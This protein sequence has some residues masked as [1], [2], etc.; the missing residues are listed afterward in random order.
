MTDTLTNLVAADALELDISGMTCAACA[1]RVERAL[2]KLD[3]VTATVNY[4][5][6]RALVTGIAPSD[7]GAAIR[8][9]ENA[10]YGAHLRKNDDDAWS[11]R[12]TEVRITSLRRRL[13]VSALLTVPLMDITI[14]LALV[15]EWRFP[16]WEW[17]CILMALPIVTWCALPFHRATIRN[18]R[19][20][21]VSMDTL[22]SLGIAAAFG[23]AVAT[24]LFG[25]GQTG[26]G[27]Y[28]LGFGITPP[29]RTR[30]T[31]MSPPG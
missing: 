23:W 9:I 19:H 22:V 2:N 21:M 29:G 16:G 31:S 12:A 14:V 1:G 15:P 11:R 3:G 4:A 27:G 17:L 25:F 20:G 8:Q 10:G 5:T 13:I 30:S 6:E 28:W 7:A 24:L 26:E 18:L